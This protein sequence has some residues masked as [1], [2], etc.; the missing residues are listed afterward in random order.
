M[1]RF[2]RVGLALAA[3]LFSACKPA[4][5]LG[6]VIDA[7]QPDS[8]ALDLLLI[9]DAGLPAPGGEPVLKALGQVVSWDP[10]RTFVVFLGDN[11]Y[12]AGMPDS[13]GAYR[14]EAERIINTQI[15]ALRSAGVRGLFV[16]GNHDWE[17]G[18]SA[19][20]SEVVR[21][22]RYVTHRGEGMVAFAPAHGCPGPVA[23]DFGQTLR[24][25]A[26]DTQW[27]LHAGPKPRGRGSPCRA[28]TEREVVDS[29]R[30][31]LRS[32]GDRPVVVVAHHPLVSGG[33]HGG[34]FD[35]PSYLFPLH[36]WAR[37]GGYFANQDV[38]G[39]E[40]R[41]M[42]TALSGAF[43]EN[44]PLVYAAGHEHNLQ[45]L[46]RDPARYLLVS[47]A[48]IYGHTTAVR[49]ITGSQYARRA[50]GF[51]RITF[52]ND[53]RARLAVLVVDAAGKATEDFSMWLDTRPSTTAT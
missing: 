21:Q 26:L 46:K 38:S 42:T 17:A 30:G 11:I 20:W 41:R 23:L 15:D 53:G 13:A 4:Y 45:V 18:G 27:W 29:I 47:G 10:K 32:A 48:G 22:E 51:M 14:A 3:L 28:G 7:A 40:Y 36:P 39:T 5:N 35:W 6:R 8:V 2:A 19:G 37:M 50:S 9:G 31:V 24:V 49:A 16:P 12:P 33:H 52:L 43:A 44:P 34:Y 25:V 1:M